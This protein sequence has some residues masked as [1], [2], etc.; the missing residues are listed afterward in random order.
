MVPVVTIHTLGDMYVPFGLEQNYLANAKA[1]GRSGLLVQRAI[2]APGHCDFTVGEQSRAFADLARWV[3]Q[4]V[5][6]AG[7]DVAT[8]STVA[9]PAYGCTFTDNTLVTDDTAS[10]KAARAPGKLPACSAPK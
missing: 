5:K 8:A 2:R 4:G 1:K 10:V 9:D 3:E 6:P 7:D